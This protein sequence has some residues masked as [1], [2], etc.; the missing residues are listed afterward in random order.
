[1][2]TSREQQNLNLI[3]NKCFQFESHQFGIPN[4]TC[5][6]LNDKHYVFYCSNCGCRIEASILKDGYFIKQLVKGRIIKTSVSP[7]CAGPWTAQR[8]THDEHYR[9]LTCEDIKNENII[10]DILE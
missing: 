7:N 9:C 8:D 6:F 2:K 4:I 3:R 10:K 1:M 5:P